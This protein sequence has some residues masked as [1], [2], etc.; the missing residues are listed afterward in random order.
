MELK[1]P[2][3]PRKG[4]TIKVEPIREKRQIK[5]I[6]KF[7]LRKS[8]RDYAIFTLGINSALRA[9]DLLRIKADKVR[10]L[11]QG[12]HFEIIEK[13]TKKLRNVTLNGASYKAIQL[14]LENYPLPKGKDILLFPSNAGENQIL[15]VPTLN[16]KVK[17]WCGY[18][19]CK[20]NYGSHTLRKTFGYHQRVTFDID[21]P[22]LMTA[23]NHS[24]QKQTL[25]YLGIQESDLHEVFMNEI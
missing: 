12:E 5:K 25:T 22:T 3:H 13:K 9:S 8:L 18:A 19:D 2:N 7:L 23:F 11:K 4:S 15:Q 21:I 1:N 20:G 24:N 6:K 14:Y 10:H 17:A 16:N